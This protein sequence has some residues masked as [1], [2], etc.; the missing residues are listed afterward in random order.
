[1]VIDKTIKVSKSA[2]DLA[3]G[4]VTFMRDVKKAMADGFQPGQDVPVIILAAYQDLFSKIPALGQL[5]PELA[6]DKYAFQRAWA[7]AGID[8][9]KVLLG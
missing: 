6:E 5:G 8:I 7:E 4:L 1:M 2:D 9:E 3:Q